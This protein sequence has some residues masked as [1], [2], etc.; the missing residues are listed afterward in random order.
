MD[1]SVSPG[2]DDPDILRSLQEAVESSGET[3][4]PCGWSGTGP[5]MNILKLNFSWELSCPR[6]GQDLLAID[7]NP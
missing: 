3:R 7:I 6:C 2:P 5:E 1:G 4:C